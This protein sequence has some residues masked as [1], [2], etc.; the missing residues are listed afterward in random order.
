MISIPNVVE[1]TLS[2]TTVNIN[3]KFTV[4]VQIEE[5]EGDILRNYAND[6]YSNE[7]QGE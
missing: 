7:L 6:F 4:A 3:T 1:V 2:S 5:I